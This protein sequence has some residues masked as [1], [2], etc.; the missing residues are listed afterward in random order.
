MAGRVT[1]TTRA[2]ALLQPQRS[3]VLRWR[4]GPRGASRRGRAR[5]LDKPMLLSLPSRLA[6]GSSP[7]P[8]FHL[9]LPNSSRPCLTTSS[10][11]P[12]RTCTRPKHLWLLCYQ[13]DLALLV[14]AP[15]Q[16]CMKCPPGQELRD[17][18]CVQALLSRTPIRKTW[19]PGQG[20]NPV[21]TPAQ[22]APQTSGPGARVGQQGLCG[23]PSSFGGRHSL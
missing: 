22:A 12:S 7:C 19:R 10:R 1:Q 9:G 11:K 5:G 2:S 3:C 14:Y 21:S 13:W 16:S 4:T 23:P 15:W 20:S 18:S 17:H 8:P 6:P